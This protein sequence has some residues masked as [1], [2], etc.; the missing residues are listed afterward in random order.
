MR[1]EGYQI[2]MRPVVEDDLD[3]LRR[4]RND[5]QISQQMISQQEITEEQ[6]LAWFKRIANDAGQRHFIILYKD[7]PIGSANIKARGIG[8]TLESAKTIEPG[9]YIAEEK[10]RNNILAFSPSLVIPLTSIR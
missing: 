8:H 4:W 5:P 9:L 6:Q 10:Y 2:I 3:M 1:L 7:A